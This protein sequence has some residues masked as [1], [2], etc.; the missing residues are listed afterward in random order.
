MGK[1][2]V[3]GRNARLEECKSIFFLTL[4]FHRKGFEVS[5][6]NVRPKNFQ[7]PVPKH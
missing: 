1:G 5:F 7:L 4:Y 3:G 2:A 6:P